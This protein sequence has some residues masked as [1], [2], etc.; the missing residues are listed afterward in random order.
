MEKKHLA[1]KRLGDSS[2]SHKINIAINTDCICPRCGNGSRELVHCGFYETHSHG[3]DLS[4][5]IYIL[6]NCPVCSRVSLVEYSNITDS[7]LRYDKYDLTSCLATVLPTPNAVTEFSPLIAKVSPQFPNLYNQAEVAEN[8]GCKAI[9]G[10]GYRKALEFLVKDYLCHVYP[11][12][13]DAILADK[14]LAD[15]INRIENSRIKTL[16]QK[17]S[18]LGN[19]ESHYLK[20]HP[21]YDISTMKSFITVMVQYMVMELTFEQADQIPSAR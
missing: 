11:D 20:L 1:I 21:E 3:N 7:Q 16:A 8:H 2:S 17:G 5:N 13:K 12:K 14:R 10:M 19:D 9:C 4:L 18:W 6:L 15:S